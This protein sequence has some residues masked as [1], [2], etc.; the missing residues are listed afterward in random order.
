MKRLDTICV[1]KQENPCKIII[2]EALLHQKH[3]ISFTLCV[4]M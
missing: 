2:T 4:Y 3:C 1:E